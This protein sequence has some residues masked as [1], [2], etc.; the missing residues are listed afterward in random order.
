M[1]QKIPVVQPSPDDTVAQVR[2]TRRAD[3]QK[4]VE[5]LS[6]REVRSNATQGSGW[7][8]VKIGK[9][10]VLLFHFSSYRQ[11]EHSYRKKEGTINHQLHIHRTVESKY[12]TLARGEGANLSTSSDQKWELKQPKKIS[13]Q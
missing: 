3:W 8:N 6:W 10:N 5:H 4:R 1:F 9:T 2:E 12:R 11:S 13:A 7:Q